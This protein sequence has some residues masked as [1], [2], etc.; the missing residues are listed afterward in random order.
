MDGQSQ[1][2]TDDAYSIGAVARLT[3]ISTHALRIWE[4]RYGTV[5]ARRTETGRRIYS[6]RDVE[7]LSLLKLLVDHGFSIG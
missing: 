2:T 5:V 7:K 6:R 4:R 1:V 3:G